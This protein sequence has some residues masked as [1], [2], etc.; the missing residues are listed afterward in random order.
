M[1][2]IDFDTFQDDEIPQ[3]QPVLSIP[4]SSNIENIGKKLSNINQFTKNFLNID[5]N[6]VLEPKESES[7]EKNLANKYANLTIG[8]IKDSESTN[9]WPQQADIARSRNMLSSR[10]SRVFNNNMTDNEIREIFREIEQSNSYLNDLIDSGIEGSNSR[11]WFR[12]RIELN[13]IKAH[14][15]FL[16]DFNPVINDISTIEGSLENLSSLVS[17]MNGILEKEALATDK[18]A[19]DIQ[20]ISD[21]K[22]LNEI[23]KALLTSFRDKFTLNVYEEHV[24]RDGE[25]GDEFF[26]VL[27]KCEK[28][29]ADCSILLTSENQNL[30]LR[31]MAKFT[32]YIDH[33]I[34]RIMNFLKKTLDNLLILSAN[35]K[36]LLVRKSLDF[37]RPRLNYFNIIVDYFVSSRSKLI[38]DEFLSQ[39]EGSFDRKRTDD[40]KVQDS[41]PLFYSAHDP[42]RYFGDLLAYVH[43]LVANEHETVSTIF[44]TTDTTEESQAGEQE[45]SLF[46]GKVNSG[47]FASLSKLLKSKIVQVV[48]SETRLTTLY[49]IFNIVDLY[50]MMLSK[51]FHN[52]CDEDSTLLKLLKE[53]AESTQNRIMDIVQS[54][55]LTIKESNVAQI[56]LTSDLQPPGWVLEFYSSILPILDLSTSGNFMNLSLERQSEFLAL[57]VDYP[58]SILDNHIKK[59]MVKVFSKWE[60][61]ICKLNF[62]DLVL[63]KIM[64]ISLL[65]EKISLLNQIID[66]TTSE[67]IKLQLEKLLIETNLNDYYNIVN[68]IC[69]LT[70]DFFSVSIYQSITE[71]KLFQKDKILEA[72]QQL[73]EKLPSALFE[74]QQLLLKLNSPSL[75]NNVIEQSS[76]EF[77]KFY[78]KYDL[79][80]KEYVGESLFPWSDAEVSTLLGIEQ[81]YADTKKQMVFD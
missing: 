58:I 63:T 27:K 69:P 7:E 80:V 5:E 75:A 41:T 44:S 81:Q 51:Y 34:E 32:K 39:L 16:K 64:P 40:S 66:T 29:H 49:S 53:C 73:E 57:V 71:N 8:L 37:L 59:N 56:E 31:V 61:C 76:L 22:K 70:D 30:G 72:R 18:F 35:K 38:V 26:G 45:S 9:E 74:A 79:I 21:E 42:V 50:V 14:E 13:L 12:S 68:M 6:V 55:L 78:C 4:I 17:N 77:T 3:P 10:L 67:L 15:A 43:S 19:R 60:R 25:I 2:F 20:N 11:K 54:K 47:I 28:I 33:S 23:K 62:Y 65:T 24:I 1:D 52:D 46:A 48:S 36:F